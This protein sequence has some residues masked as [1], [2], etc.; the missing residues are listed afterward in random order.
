MDCAEKAAALYPKSLY[1]INRAVWGEFT[2]INNMLSYYGLG[3]LFDISEV[4]SLFQSV[5]FAIPMGEILL[6][7]L[8]QYE[9]NANEWVQKYQYLL[10]ELGKGSS[11]HSPP[12]IKR[13]YKVNLKTISRSMNLGSPRKNVKIDYL[14]HYK[15]FALFIL[16]AILIELCELSSLDF[17]LKSIEEHRH[18]FFNFIFWIFLARF[19]QVELE[20]SWFGHFQV[21]FRD[22]AA[23]RS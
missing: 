14:G 15:I 19:R 12:L 8:L 11:F 18:P 10:E 17:G 1:L 6:S 7:N 22:S 23:S 16:F 2:N 5:I 4:S 21:G 9:E 13:S 3:S 20:N